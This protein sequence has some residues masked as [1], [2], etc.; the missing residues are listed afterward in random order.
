MRAVFFAI[1]ALHAFAPVPA[2]AA[3]AVPKV[4]ENA[5]ITEKLGAQVNLDL[6]FVDHQGRAVRLRDYLDG[7]RPVILTL[8]YYEC[9]SLC[10]LQLNGFVEGLKA[11]EWAPGTHYRIVTV[12]IDA[13]ETAEL[14]AGKRASYLKALGRG[15][16][17][18]SFLTGTTESIRALADT[19]GFGFN[20]VKEEDQFAHA[21]G[22]MFL[23][24][25]GVVARYLYGI[26]Y[27]P[28]DLRFAL[29]ETAAGRVGSVVDR[30]LLSCFHYDDKTGR[31]TPYAF[32]IMR[33]GGVLTALAVAVM[34]GV[35]WRA[36]RKVSSVSREV[37][38]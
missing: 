27:R 3:E 16:V 21:A 20:Y 2:R 22:I 29:M 15:D 33:A 6:P 25:E 13:R 17:D 19:V 1:F 32:G 35:L 36:E 4:L 5:V 8:N 23:S 10:S 24:P 28:M 37:M 7:S 9:P 11:F 12:S 18:W 31:Y 34:L 14:A 30:L 26:E 38:P